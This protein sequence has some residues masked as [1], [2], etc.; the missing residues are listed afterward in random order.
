M[1]NKIAKPENKKSMSDFMKLF[2]GIII[3]IIAMVALKFLAGALG[4]M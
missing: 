1:E 4:I 2:I 3:V